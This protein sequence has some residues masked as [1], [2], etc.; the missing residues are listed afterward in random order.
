MR[1]LLRAAALLVLWLAPAATTWAADHVLAIS[2]SRYDPV[3]GVPSLPGVR[4]DRSNIL[5]IAR[6]FGFDETRTLHL[7]DERA[8]LDGIRRELAGLARQL[9]QAAARD[10][11]ADA[12]PVDNPPGDPTHPAA[13]PD[14]THW[15]AWLAALPPPAWQLLVLDQAEVLAAGLPPRVGR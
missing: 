10:W 1:H 7:Q 15:A 14:V 9:A 11:A 13:P 4:Q 6:E 3:L 8:T 2:V 12:A 5:A